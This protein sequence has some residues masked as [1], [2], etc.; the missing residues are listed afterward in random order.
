LGFHRGVTN[1]PSTALLAAATLALAIGAPAVA[2]AQNVAVPG[3]H[4]GATMFPDLEAVQHIGLQFYDFTEFDKLQDPTGAYRRYNDIDSTIGF[5]LITLSNT[6]NLRREDPFASNLLLRSAFVAGYSFDQPTN[7]LQNDVIH[8][9][10]GL[11]RVPRGA[12]ME[13][14]LLNYAAE[15]NYNFHAIGRADD[16]RLQFV[17][18]PLF[19]GAG[20]SAGTIM[21][22][23]YVQGGLHQFSSARSYQRALERIVFF[24]VSAMT[25]VGVTLPGFVITDTQLFYATGQGAVRA[26]FASFSFPIVAEVALTGTTGVFRR[27]VGPE[28][29]PY[30]AP[31]T[32]PAMVDRVA[33][34]EY[35]VA[36][37]L[38]LGD[39]VFETVNDFY[40]GKDRGPT[41]GASVYY[42]LLPGSMLSRLVGWL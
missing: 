5:N 15:L 35:F 16:G 9:V 4:F 29:G 8:K 13:R 26:H 12:T 27:G 19:V 17:P 41:Y 32:A 31:T 11:P 7:A 37:R 39:F 2:R 10:G 20:F 28:F 40:G 38:R 30:V 24:S 33:L 25:R 22:D 21:Q 34:P 14:P 18:T 1:R 23:L 6:R 3:P 42:V 36:F